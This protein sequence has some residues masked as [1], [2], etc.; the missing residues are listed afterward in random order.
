[1]RNQTN[2]VTVEDNPQGRDPAD[3]SGTDGQRIHGRPHDENRPE[4]IHDDRVFRFITG[5]RH[6]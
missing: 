5:F 1:M 6:N 2:E 4:R 3:E